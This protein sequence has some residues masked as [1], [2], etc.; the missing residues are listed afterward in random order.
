M[1][2]FSRHFDFRRD[3]KKIYERRDYESVAR[4]KEPIFGYVPENDENKKRI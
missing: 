2:P 1:A 3:H 4:W